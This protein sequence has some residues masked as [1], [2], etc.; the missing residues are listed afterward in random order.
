[1]KDGLVVFLHTFVAAFLHDHQC[2]TLKF[3]SVV[4]FT[5]TSN[6]PSFALACFIGG[7]GAFT[8]LNVLLKPRCPCAAESESAFRHHAD[9]S[10]EESSFG[11][12]HQPILRVL[13][14]VDYVVLVAKRKLAYTVDRY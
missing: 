7:R 11:Q 3:T 12:F 1:M 10:H 9:I 5:V 2:I 8:F 14:T 13:W 6:I 4:L